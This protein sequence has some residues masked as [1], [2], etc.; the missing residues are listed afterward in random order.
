MRFNRFIV[1][2]AVAA[3]SCLTTAVGTAAPASAAATLVEDCSIDEQVCLYYNSSTYGYGAVFKQTGPISN[4]QGYYFSAGNNGS[5]GAGTQVKNNAAAVDNSWDGYFF[6]IYYNSNY[7][8][9]YACQTTDPFNQAD[10][11]S[12]MKNNNASGRI[13]G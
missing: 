11:T 7:D 1:A 3:A 5:A 13:V 6:R 8:C 10:L 4:Y 9:S 2:G 12:T